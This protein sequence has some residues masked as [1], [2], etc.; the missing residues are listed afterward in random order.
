MTGK[1]EE[2]IALE[3]S[4]AAAVAAEAKKAEKAAAQAAKAAEK[5]AAKE[6]ADAEKAAKKAEKEAAAKAKEDAKAAKEAEKA[7]KVAAKEAAKAAKARPEQNGVK[8]RTAGTKTGRVWEICNTVSARLGQPAPVKD[9]LEAAAAE[10][11]HP[12]TTRCQY[13]HWKKYHGL[14]GRITAPVP[15][16]ETA[17][18]A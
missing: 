4:Q 1:T 6:K 16:G 13:A 17:Q 8:E 11:L 15:V 7:A 3:K 10:G 18:A 2:Q 14:T 9:V 5:L 12:T